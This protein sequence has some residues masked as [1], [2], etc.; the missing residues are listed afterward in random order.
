MVFISLSIHTNFEHE[1]HEDIPKK[2]KSLSP[3]A[4]LNP[5]A[6]SII[7][8]KWKR[9]NTNQNRPIISC[10]S[11]TTKTNLHRHH[12]Q[13]PSQ[14]QYHSKKKKKKKPKPNIFLGL[15]HHWIQI[16]SSMTSQFSSSRW[17]KQN[18]RRWR[19]HGCTTLD[20]YLSRRE[21]GRWS[22]IWS[23]P[24]PP[25][26]DPFPQTSTNQNNTQT[27]TKPTSKA[28]QTPSNYR[29]AKPTTHGPQPMAS[30]A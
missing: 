20:P 2:I 1:K 9:T 11:S 29:R 17:K 5:L 16:S 6:Y 26:K 27:T 23:H 19:G 10:L 14:N 13:Y 30:K 22:P 7:N 25:P 24:K 12:N 4:S 8:R 15:N 21:R 3:I 18:H 28:T